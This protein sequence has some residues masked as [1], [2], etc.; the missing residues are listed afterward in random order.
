MTIKEV[1]HREIKYALCRDGA[2]SDL[3]SPDRVKLNNRGNVSSTK[4]PDDYPWIIFRRITETENN[5]VPYV[6]ERV[7]I[8]IIGLRGNAE[9][10]DELIEQVKD[11]IKNHF[12]G[13]LKT[14]GKFTEDG[15][16][17]P[18]G[19]LRLK[20]RY[21]S[22]IDDHE[23]SLTELSQIMIFFFSAIR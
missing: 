16:A 4:S 6:R 22:T 7:E 17:D 10:G 1:L 19:G 12:K 11:A 23:T 8:E 2:L 5:I 15:A 9:K 3:V 20:C 13:K 18:T 14:Y 21:E